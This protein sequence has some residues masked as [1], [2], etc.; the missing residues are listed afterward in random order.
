AFMYTLTEL[1]QRLSTLEYIGQHK[2]NIVVSERTTGN[3]T[4]GQNKTWSIMD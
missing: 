2:E 1:C 3:N 4:T